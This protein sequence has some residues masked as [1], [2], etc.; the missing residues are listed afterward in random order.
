MLKRKNK[1]K[2][3]TII[4]V[5]IV[6]A[7]AGLIL[8]IVLLAVPALQR[9]SRNTSRK[10]DASAISAAVNNSI[11]NNNGTLPSG[12]AQNNVDANSLDVCDTGGDSSGTTT[13]FASCTNPETAKLG[14]YATTGVF[15]TTATTAITANAGNA[16]S[17]TNVSQDSVLIVT[18]A[19]CASTQA[20]LATPV[21]SP[22]SVAVYYATESSSN[23]ET[24]QCVD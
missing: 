15:L 2:G 16:G 19:S 9:A 24:L 10:N 14:Y 17:V 11:D 4:E 3:F 7:I 1:N 18:G 6:L 20:G 5:M 22:R 12:L 23:T 13:G 8:L 21:P